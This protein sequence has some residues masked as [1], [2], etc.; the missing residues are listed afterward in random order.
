MKYVVLVAAA[1]PYGH[2]LGGVMTFGPFDTY[3][4]GEEWIKA[5]DFRTRGYLV[6]EL[7]TP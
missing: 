1:S 3:D 6:R 2:E 4:E 7:V 5:Q